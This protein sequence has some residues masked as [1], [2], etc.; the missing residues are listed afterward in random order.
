M[1]PGVAPGLPR[2]RTWQDGA[3]CRQHPEVNF[4]PERGEPVDDAVAICQACPVRERCLSEGLYDNFGIWGGTSGN[5]RRRL[6][7]KQRGQAA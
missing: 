5:Q 1:L 4:F 3:L 6:R 7:A 2:L